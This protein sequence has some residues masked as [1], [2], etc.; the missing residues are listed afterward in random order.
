MRIIVQDYGVQE[1]YYTEV[2]PAELEHTKKVKG[3]QMSIKITSY[4]LI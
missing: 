1:Y 2:Q 3:F 4:N